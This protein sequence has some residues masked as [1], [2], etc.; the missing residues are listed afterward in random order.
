MVLVPVYKE[1]NLQLGLEP[2][3]LPVTFT[4]AILIAKIEF[5][6]PAIKIYA[7]LLTPFTTEEGIGRVYVNSHRLNI[8]Q[9]KYIYVNLP[10]FPNTYQLQFICSWWLRVR[11][12]TLS[13]WEYT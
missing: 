3:I 2:Y 9:S 4:G 11:L 5:S 7:G 10:Y 6:N 8:N 12:F 1:D 13:I